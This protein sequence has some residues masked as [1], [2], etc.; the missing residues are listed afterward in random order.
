MTDEQ[1]IDGCK[2]R[3]PLAQ[4]NL[5]EK[6]SRKMMAVCMRYAD[7]REEAQD[8]LQDGFV[9]V[10][11][12]IGTFQGQG[13][14]DGW[15]RRIFV[16]TALDSIRRNRENR[17]LADIDDVGYS[18][19]SGVSVDASIN[20]EELM[21]ILQKIPAGYRVVFNM[22]AIEGYSH[23]EIADQL[24]VSESTSKTQFLRAKAFLIK[25]LQKQKMID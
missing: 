1:L 24:G 8:I 21:G 13:S 19:D 18:L 16:N 22:F 14:F 10:F 6:Y 17:L 9:K 12:K 2:A 25:V 23:K 15:I 11:E 7:S 4:R 20:A 3:N 5:Y